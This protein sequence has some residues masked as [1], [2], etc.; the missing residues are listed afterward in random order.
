MRRACAVLIATFS[1]AGCPGP[2]VSL[3]DAET[4][5]ASTGSATESGGLPTASESMTSAAATGGGNGGTEGEATSSVDTADTGEEGSGTD[6][7]PDTG[8]GETD[9]STGNQPP[10][11]ATVVFINFA[12]P[13]L[14]QGVDDATADVTSIGQMAMAL[15]PFG[16]G[17]EQGAIVSAVQDKFAGLNMFATSE[18]PQSGDY[19]MVVVTPTNP[20][21]GAA[22]IAPLDC[23]DGNPTSVAFVFASK[24]GA[25]IGSVAS[26]VAREVG[27]TM[28]LEHVD[29][30]ADLLNQGFVSD[31]AEFTDTCEMLVA[32][33]SCAARHA[34]HCP[35]QQQN[36]YAELLSLVG[37]A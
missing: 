22:A 7:S 25:S 34:A 27:S 9:G 17:A 13:T 31:D 36:S 15:D 23:G 37:P 19:A 18:R 30:P 24:G 35:A 6:T 14:T 21:G 1:L 11:D 12:G 8:D 16:E 4:D 33:P 28:G 32:A 29:A 2:D 26:R 5:S 20:F 10:V 3:G